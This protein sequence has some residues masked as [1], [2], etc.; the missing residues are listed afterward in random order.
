MQ[1]ER[2]RTGE[3]GHEVALLCDNATPH[4]ELMTWQSL[5]SF[6][7]VI[8]RTVRTSHYLIIICF[9]QDDKQFRTKIEVCK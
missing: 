8:R 1:T 5:T 7:C 9:C 4:S 3:R 6:K 2:P